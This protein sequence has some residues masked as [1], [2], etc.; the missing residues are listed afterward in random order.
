MPKN[1]ISGSAFLLKTEPSE[2]SFEQLEREGATVWSGVRNPEARK[3]LRAMRVGD[4]AFI[5]H[6]GKAPAIVGLAK[7]TREAY[8]EPNA[9]QWSAVDLVPLRRLMR[10]LT[11][12]ELKGISALSEW[13]L[14]RR[15]RLSVVPVN[16]D[17]LAW[18]EKL[19]TMS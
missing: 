4:A 15:S 11:L 3:N 5:Y 8:P 6:S 13:A 9:E 12:A 14:I 7:V 18:L 1:Q 19:E 16:C 10:P 17:Q 2:Y